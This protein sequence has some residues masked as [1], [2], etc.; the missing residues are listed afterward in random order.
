[1]TP[2]APPF[3]PPES[4]GEVQELAHLYT[5]TGLDAQEPAFAEWLE[6]ST[7][8][9]QDEFSSEVDAVTALT[10]AIIGTESAPALDLAVI[11]KPARIFP[12]G[13]DFVAH[14]AGGWK[15][16]PIKGAR[17]KECSNNPADGFAVMILE[18]EPGA[19]FFSH[20]HKGS[21]QVYLLE[22]DLVSDGQTLEPGDFLRAGP[23]THH[24]G[25]HSETGCRA[26]IVM[27]QNNYPSRA[28]TL[29]DRLIRGT[30]KLLGK[31]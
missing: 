11:T 3:R 5:T 26:L 28:I 2:S 22:G 24:G 8:E 19:R 6:N 27:A 17:I 13:F 4:T 12:P 9:T 20:S 23:G 30:R 1:M 21:E 29:Y 18:M 15:E 31:V 7:L 16:L 14:D 25:L 10:L